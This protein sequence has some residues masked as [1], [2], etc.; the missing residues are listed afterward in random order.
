MVVFVF[1][2]ECPGTLYFVTLG[3]T[4]SKWLG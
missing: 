2:V 1:A 4:C 3:I